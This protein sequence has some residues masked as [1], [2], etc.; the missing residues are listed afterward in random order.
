[1]MRNSILEEIYSAREKLFAD[2]KD[3]IHA[4]V[5]EARKRALSSGRPIAAPKTRSKENVA[6]VEQNVLGK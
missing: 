2:Y 3:D 4:Y 5:L 6:A 1:M